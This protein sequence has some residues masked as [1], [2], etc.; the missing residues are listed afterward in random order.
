MSIEVAELEQAVDHLPDNWA[1]RRLLDIC[2]PRQWPTISREQFTEN[3]YPVYGA[4]GQIGFYS[5]FTHDSETIAI[6]CRGATCG[7]I[8]LVPAKSYI[9]GN[10]MAL[11][12]LDDSLVAQSYLYQALQHW[13]VANSIS[14]SAQPQITRQSL[15]HVAFP[16][17]PLD[18]QRRVAEVL[19]SVDEAIAAAVAAADLAENL[20]VRVRDEV[21]SQPIWG[22][23][24]LSDATSA[25]LFTDGDW[26]ESKDQD[27]NGDVRLIQL[28][29]IGDG[30]FVDK[31]RRY[32]TLEKAHQLR[33]T[34]LEE[35]DLLIARMP[36][37]LGRCCLFPAI[38]QPSVTVVDVCVVRASQITSNRYLNHAIATSEFR[39]QVLA[40][41]S[42]TTRTRVS[43]GNLGQLELAMPPL[44]EQEAIADELDQISVVAGEQQ[45][46]AER[47]KDLK[48]GLMSDLFS[49]R[50]RVPA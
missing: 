20:L 21:I 39:S 24:T 36:D 7:T 4:N 37:P 19:R 17:P 33:C 13:G 48:H 44:A 3:G 25:G 35:G 23:T 29:D 14:G 8:N 31:S 41:A 40:C 6:T 16:F 50:V 32:L 11:D 2:R 1:S 22:M 18:E 34:F 10:A 43:R 46:A 30:C 42:G 5:Q 15:N 12:D 45:Q 27:P 9:T 47:L 26:V 49:G 38:N 28:A